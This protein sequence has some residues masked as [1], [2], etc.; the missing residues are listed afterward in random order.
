MLPKTSNSNNSEFQ[1]VINQIR[2]DN[3]SATATIGSLKESLTKSQNNIATEI[4]ELTAMELQN[5]KQLLTSLSEN[6]DNVISNIGTH[7]TQRLVGINQGLLTGASEDRG[8]LKQIRTNTGLFGGRAG[9]IGTMKAWMLSFKPFT[10]ERRAKARMKQRIA[11]NKLTRL[12]W[13]E[14]KNTRQLLE[15]QVL[16]SKEKEEEQKRFWKQ[17]FGSRDTMGWR[18]RRNLAPKGFWGKMVSFFAL[19]AGAMGAIIY[20]HLFR[21]KLLVQGIFKFA[22]G[23]SSIIETTLRSPKVAGIM[24]KLMKS[25]FIGDV[26]ELLGNLFGGKQVREFVKSIKSSNVI[27]P[28][29]AWLGKFSSSLKGLK[30]FSSRSIPILG[31]VLSGLSHLILWIRTS[32]IITKGISFIGKLLKGSKFAQAIPVV[33]Q[34]ISIVIGA[35]EAIRGVIKGVQKIGGIKG[36]ITGLF[37]GVMEFFTLGIFDMDKF[38]VTA[39]GAFD[40]FSN[41]D[42]LGGVMQLIKA[43]FDGIV[44]GVAWLMEKIGLGM[45]GG[46]FDQKVLV[47]LVK[48]SGCLPDHSYG[49]SKHQNGYFLQLIG[50]KFLVI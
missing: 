8:L 22:K 33:G 14:Q 32:P 37:G 5:S 26:F 50:K 49:Y 41:G 27:S 24:S 34:L 15:R 16:G 6:I 44:S 9:V 46:A 13:N 30:G 10:N 20:D 7:G 28:L 31:K 1:G 39:K 35:Y 11:L 42:F 48:H 45:H 4:D 12:T 47:C 21:S 2:K 43:P 23:L 40:K 25:G 19:S 17:L 3:S 18:D 36:A 38:L 29:F